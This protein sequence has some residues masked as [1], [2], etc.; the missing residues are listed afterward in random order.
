MGYVTGITVN[1]ERLRFE[2]WTFDAWRRNELED[3]FLKRLLQR[4]VRFVPA[5]RPLAN[6]YVRDYD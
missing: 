2:E 3:A 6:P 5:G 4:C 1:G